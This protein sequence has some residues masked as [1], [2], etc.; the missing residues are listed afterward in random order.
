MCRTHKRSRQKQGSL[1]NN[2]D[3][4]CKEYLIC[5]KTIHCY[6]KDQEISEKQSIES[7]WDVNFASYNYLCAYHRCIYGT[8]RKPPKNCLFPEHQNTTS[9]SSY[10]NKTYNYLTIFYERK[11]PISG[12]LFMKHA[13]LRNILLSEE[14]KDA[15]DLNNSYTSALDPLVVK[16]GHI[17]R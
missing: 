14:N 4:S 1:V 2:L 10:N 6:S 9:I 12:T 3:V 7:C 16:S 13:K 5:S 17:V 11:F 8:Y 15:C